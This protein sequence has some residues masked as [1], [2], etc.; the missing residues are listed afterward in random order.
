M[1]VWILT[2]EYNDYNQHGEYFIAAFQNKPTES[3][4]FQTCS[5]AGYYVNEDDVQHILNG[6]GR[7]TDDK[8]NDYYSWFYLREEELK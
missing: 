4:I 5:E 3:Q 1:K 6:G 2:S 8:Y 7:R